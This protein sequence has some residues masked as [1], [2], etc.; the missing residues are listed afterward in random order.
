MSCSCNDGRERSDNES[1]RVVPPVQNQQEA[2]PTAPLHAEAGQATLPEE[3]LQRVPHGVIAAVLRDLSGA[4]DFTRSAWQICQRASSAAG[5]ARTARVCARA[6]SASSSATRM[7]TR[8][9]PRAH[10]SDDR[11]S[12]R[13][14]LQ[15]L[16]RVTKPAPRRQSVLVLLRRTAKPTPKLVTRAQR[17]QLQQLPGPRSDTRELGRLVVQQTARGRSYG[18]AV[19]RAPVKPG[20]ALPGQ[21]SVAAC[22]VFPL[23]RADPMLC[24]VEDADATVEADDFSVIYAGRRR[25]KADQR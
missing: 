22:S 7:S 8:A 19:Q 1:A 13:L 4:A 2:R 24:S 20:T 11:H 14:L 6:P 21:Q 5:P 18:G 10:Q 25:Q 12:P 9:T 15:Q 23:L 17:R 16:A 3:V